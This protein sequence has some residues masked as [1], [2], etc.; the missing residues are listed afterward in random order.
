MTVRFRIRTPQGQ[1]LSFASQAVFVEFI[2]SGDLAPEDLVYDGETNEWAPARTHPLVLEIQYEEEERAEA[3][4]R[5][6]DDRD[7]AEAPAPTAADLGLD[8]A[9]PLPPPPEDT[10][11]I[12]QDATDAVGGLETLSGLELAPPAPELSPEEEAAAFLRKLES[13]RASELDAPRQVSLGI[14]MEDSGSLAGMISQPDSPTTADRPEVRA[15]RKPATP[16]PRPS[17]KPRGVP[18]A[19]KAAVGVGVVAVLGIGT[20]L[21]LGSDEPVLADPVEPQDS[22]APA[23]PPAPPPP[24]PV[25]AS[26]PEAVRARAQERFLSA[27]QALLRDLPPIPDSWLTGAY[28]VLPSD[29]EEVRSIWQSYLDAARLVRGGDEERYRIAY[30]RALDEAGIQGD[31]RTVRLSTALGAFATRTDARNAHWDRVEALAVAAIQSHNALVEIEGQVLHDATGATGRPDG[32]GAGVSGRDSDS[33]LR[34][35]QV[36]ELLGS[37]LAADGMGPRTGSNVREWV[38]GGFL[39]AVTY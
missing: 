32:I 27:T 26:T 19:L 13:E 24:P 36:I 17:E 14:R 33:Q 39:N 21:A 10:D 15:E 22:I 30:E 25:I 38:W 29:H 7:G 35:T 23:P 8:L 9:D 18:T 28:F 37:R 5:E 12:Y 31:D 1:E 4:A 34:V 11:P 20:W 3:A 6:E 2:R 16:R